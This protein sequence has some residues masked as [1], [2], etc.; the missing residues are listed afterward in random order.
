MLRR[1]DTEAFQTAAQTTTKLPTGQSAINGQVAQ[2]WPV[3]GAK[4]GW[5]GDCASWRKPSAT[6]VTRRRALSAD[7]GQRGID[8]R[9]GSTVYDYPGTLPGEPKGDGKPN[10]GGGAGYKRCL[11]F[12]FQIHNELRGYRPAQI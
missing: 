11:V 7:P 8:P 5:S 2:W 10:A 9:L 6:T 12:Q 3:V 1:A 4:E